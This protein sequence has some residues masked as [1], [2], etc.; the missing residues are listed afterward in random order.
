M[1]ANKFMDSD[2]NYTIPAEKIRHLTMDYADGILRA[3]EFIHEIANILVVTCILELK[4]IQEHITEFLCGS[5]G[6]KS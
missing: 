4:E 2:I 5:K 6:K 1:S 3:D